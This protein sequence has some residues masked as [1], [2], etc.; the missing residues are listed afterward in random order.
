[1]DA[2]IF[3]FAQVQTSVPYEKL[4]LNFSSSASK[5]N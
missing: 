5:E 3:I 2:G 4:Y 1:M